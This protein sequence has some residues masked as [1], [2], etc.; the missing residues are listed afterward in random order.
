[1]YFFIKYCYVYC[2][3]KSGE[4][5]DQ[6]FREGFVV[7]AFEERREL[8]SLQAWSSLNTSVP[9]PGMTLRRFSNSTVNSSP[10]LKFSGVIQK[11]FSLERVSITAMSYL[12]RC[13]L[14]Q[15]RAW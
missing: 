5:D 14:E 12:F 7:A 15:S 9:S 3:A 4:M 6:D 1:M 11:E 2:A 10:S 8:R 13:A